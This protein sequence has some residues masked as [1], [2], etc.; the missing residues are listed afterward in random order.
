MG[1]NAGGIPLGRWI[2]L[3][4]ASSLAVRED[5]ELFGSAGGEMTVVPIEGISF[6]LRA[7]ARRP[8]LRAQRALTG[9]FGMQVDRLTLDYG[10][11]D[12]R[13]KGGAHRITLRMR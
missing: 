13:G 9:G 7:G 11:E 6:S 10:W 4:M 3:G 5:G 2:D 12:M 1:A 8:E